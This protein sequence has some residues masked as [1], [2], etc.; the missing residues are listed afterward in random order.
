MVIYMYLAILIVTSI[1]TGII[2]T[3]LERKGFYPLPQKKN[4]KAKEEVQVV[5]QQQEVYSSDPV[6]VSAKTVFNMQPVVVEDVPAITDDYNVPQLISSYTVDLSGVISNIG[7]IEVG[8]TNQVNNTNM[9]TT[10]GF[11]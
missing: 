1:I 7:Q 8:E 4:K 3:I 6:I 2:V 5:E 11:V 9:G 10:E